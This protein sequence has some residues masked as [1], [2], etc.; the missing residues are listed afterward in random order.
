MIKES[1][2]H[3]GPGNADSPPANQTEQRNPFVNDKFARISRTAMELLGIPDRMLYRSKSMAKPTTIFNANLYDAKAD[4][5]WYGDLE[6]ERDAEAL[7]KLSDVSGPIYVLWERDGRFPK[8]APTMAYIKDRAIVTVQNGAITYTSEFQERVD[9][10]KT[11]EK[12][13]LTAEKKGR[14]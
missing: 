9:F 8:Q 2:Q 10:L 7:L 14:K 3:K 6:I 11:R 1:D 5:I 4:K 13:G 12:T